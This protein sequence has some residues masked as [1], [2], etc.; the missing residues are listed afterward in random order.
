MASY[1][2]FSSMSDLPTYGHDAIICPYCGY[3]DSDDLRPEPVTEDY[4]CGNCGETFQLET[5][6]TVTY[7]GTKFEDIQK[8]IEESIEY[9]KNPDPKYKEDVNLPGRVTDMLM[10]ELQEIKDKIKKSKL[11]LEK[12]RQ[13][14]LFL[15]EDVKN[16]SQDS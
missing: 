16:G 3:S 8:S 1:E 7:T 9:W 14:G 4:E 6:I 13:S 2:V 11:R 15:E 5:E 10:T 12:Y